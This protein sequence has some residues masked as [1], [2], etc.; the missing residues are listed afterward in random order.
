MLT[1]IEQNL[2]ILNARKPVNTRFSQK[3]QKKYKKY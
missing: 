2:K 1:K 3:V